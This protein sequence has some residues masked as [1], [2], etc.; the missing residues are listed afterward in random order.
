MKKRFLIL[1]AFIFSCSHNELSFDY[2]S[3]EIDEIMESMDQPSWLLNRMVKSKHYT[4]SDWK[5]QL[6]IIQRESHVLVKLNHPDELF[7]KL[8]IQS[9]FELDQFIINLSKMD[10]NEQ[11]KSWIAIK[12]SCQKC[13]EV[14]D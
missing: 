1:T 11:E 10:M 2:K 3:V 6:E 7:Q 5:E 13:H 12:N 4:K 14:Y 9:S 8:A